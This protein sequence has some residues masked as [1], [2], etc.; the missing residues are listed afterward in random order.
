M[1]EI[2]IRKT[3][4]GI[5]FQIGDGKIFVYPKLS[6]VIAKLREVLGEKDGE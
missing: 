4:E 3:K 6:M 1:E 2:K 5:E